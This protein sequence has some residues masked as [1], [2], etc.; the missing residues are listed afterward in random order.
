MNTFG[1]S[2]FWFGI[3]EG[4][5][6]IPARAG[7]GRERRYEMKSMFDT[8][9]RQE[10]RSLSGESKKAEKVKGI[11]KNG[12]KTFRMYGILNKMSGVNFAFLTSGQTG[13][14]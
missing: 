6:K 2:F 5:R 14:R 8:R 3:A 9:S 11:Y 13:G 10:Y 1:S 4:K 7:E 12:L